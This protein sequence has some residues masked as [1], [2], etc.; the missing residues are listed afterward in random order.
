MTAVTRQDP[1][2]PVVGEYRILRFRKGRGM[3]FQARKSQRLKEGNYSR[4]GYYFITI[5]C[6]HRDPG[7][8]EIVHGEIHLNRFGIIAD[9]CWKTLPEHF[10]DCAI[11]AYIVMPDHFHGIIELKNDVN[12]GNNVGNRHACSLQSFRQYQRIP[13]VIGAFKSASSRLIRQSGYLEFKWQK[14]YY[15]RILRRNELPRT[16]DYIRNNPKN[17]TV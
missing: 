10:P 1:A 15:D 5:V 9:H 16:R 6:D 7:F 2:L 13:V 11:D 3:L 12:M 4:P 8:G 17:R 14:S